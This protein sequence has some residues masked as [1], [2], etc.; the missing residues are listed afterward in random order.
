MNLAAL[1]AILAGASKLAETIVPIIQRMT[2]EKRTELT[3][4]EI[5]RVKAQQ[6]TADEDWASILEQLRE[7]D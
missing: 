3:P 2:A 6:V 5:A 1:I 7:K 4:A